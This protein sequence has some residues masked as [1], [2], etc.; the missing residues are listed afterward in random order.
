MSQLGEEALHPLG[1]AELLVVY[2][3]VAQPSN[4]PG[5]EPGGHGKHQPGQ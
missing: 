2:L 3:I 5:L 1:S 4:L